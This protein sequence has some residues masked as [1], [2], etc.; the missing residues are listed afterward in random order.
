MIENVVFGGNWPV[1]TAQREFEHWQ[2]NNP[3]VRIVSVSEF[4][5]KWRGRNQISVYYDG[6]V[7]SWDRIRICWEKEQSAC[8]CDECRVAEE[9]SHHYRL[10][11]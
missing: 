11:A 8:M 4:Y 1:T 5:D 7:V 9:K 2:K 3:S 10:S 6:N